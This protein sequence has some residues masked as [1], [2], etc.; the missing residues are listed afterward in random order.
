M[1]APK[2]KKCPR[3]PQTTI[4]QHYK[5]HNGLQTCQTTDF[6]IN[7]EN[8]KDEDT[9]PGFPLVSNF[10]EEA[11]A[12][13][14]GH[15]LDQLMCDDGEV[16]PAEI[17]QI[18]EKLLVAAMVGDKTYQ[19][20]P[21]AKELLEKAV[22][23]YAFP[24]AF[25]QTVQAAFTKRVSE[26]KAAKAVGKGMKNLAI[27]DTD[28]LPANSTTDKDAPTAQPPQPPQ[29]SA[30]TALHQTA[31][32]QPA[33]FGVPGAKTELELYAARP[34]R[35]ANIITGKVVTNHFAVTL[36]PGHVLYE[37][38]IQGLENYTGISAP[39]QRKFIERFIQQSPFLAQQPQDFAT[40]GKRIIIAFKDLSTWNQNPAITAP[41]M[42]DQQGVPDFDRDQV[43]T[44]L[45]SISLNLVHTRVIDLNGLSQYVHGNNQQYR[46][47]G[48][49]QAMNILIGKGVRDNNVNNTNNN[50]HAFQIGDHRFFTPSHFRLLPS[51]MMV[52]IRGFFSSIRPGINCVLLNV[53]TVASAVY[54]QATVAKYIQD[55]P[56]YP[57]FYTNTDAQKHL[58]RL[59]VRILYNRNKPGETDMWK[60][61]AEGRIKTITG[62]SHDDAEKT[63]FQDR[64]GNSV[65][66]WNHFRMA[67]P[68]AVNAAGLRGKQICVNTRGN[69]PTKPRLAC[70]FL[71]DQLEVLDKQIYRRTLDRLGPGLTD[72]MITFASQPPEGNRTTIINHGLPALA[73]SGQGQ[74]PQVLTRSGI[75]VATQMLT[76][77]V[78]RIQFPGI[79]WK[80]NPN[81]PTKDAK[82]S[83]QGKH[84]FNTDKLMTG[85]IIFC[86]STD[87]TNPAWAGD[88]MVNFK[89]A[90][91]L[92]GI[93]SPFAISPTWLTIN[94][95]DVTNLHTHLNA[96]ARRNAGLFVLV[97]PT[98]DAKN[99]Q[100]HAA[101]RQVVDQMLGKPSL[102]FCEARMLGSMKTSEQ[103]QRPSNKSLIPYMAN[104]AMKLNVRL[105]NINHS[106]AK[107]HLSFL[108]RN[109]VCDTLVLGADLIH[110]KSNSA[111]YCPSIA[112]VVG[113]VDDDYGKFLGSV[114]RQPR[115]SEIIDPQNMR[116]M[117]LERI[118]AWAAHPAH[119]GRR[120]PARILY[121]RDGV[122]DTQYKDIRQHEIQAIR[123][124]W[125]EA[126]NDREKLPEITA[127]VVTKR[128][129]TRFYPAPGA[130]VNHGKTSNGNCMPGT[131]VDSDITSPY[132]FDFF[133]QSHVPL[134]GSAKPTHYF[135]LENG[136]NFS[137]VE[138]QDLTNTM[139]YLFAHS[140]NA[141]SYVSPAYYADKLC[142]RAALYLK[143]FFDG[144]TNP[145]S[146]QQAQ[147]TAMD[148]EW[149]RG[150]QGPNNNPWNARFN[151]KMFWM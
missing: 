96:P 145:P 83:T 4:H 35:E 104:N 109:G 138:L 56:G 106:V 37:Y 130:L 121:Y 93:V 135:V 39:K 46:E 146:T 67:Y 24:P 139:C 19:G 48:A 134:Q 110:P 2:I 18:A 73:L 99:R 21:L 49:A 79:R 91:T 86:T 84:F 9:W 137:A 25:Q 63:E 107:H 124:A 141:V 148:N 5:V 71:P 101:F 90:F 8:V 144:P 85:P 17:Q 60:D 65:S 88:Y 33:Q 66:V 117:V 69:D 41:G 82:W 62:F 78:R 15:C 100:R 81:D 12:G 13:A 94:Q 29:E 55:G 95:W 89:G 59:R 150:G 6:V 51:H 105:G 36:K 30:A 70:W 131:V 136:M 115:G 42:V 31:G 74:Q 52:A 76:V 149:N 116:T 3:C 80:N 123:L 57:G 26:K 34:A 27:Q 38:E 14:I 11:D 72:A 112:A 113:S 98:Q 77:P 97:L 127:V 50:T 22:T 132:Y 92:N 32:T 53:N 147:M 28:S 126:A 45:R 1:S 87:M 68:Q 108:S 64:A 125:Q 128:H 7:G 142:E 103:R 114:R 129:N 23:V 54:R 151:D 133:L 118:K 58:I 75:S 143:S 10:T 20:V 43:N 44:T 61:S 47:T 122:N 16:Q 102:V 140:T 40:D 119:V 111:D 120:V